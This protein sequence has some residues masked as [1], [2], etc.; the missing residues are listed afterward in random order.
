MKKRLADTDSQEQILESFKALAGDK[1]FVTE[2]DLRRS[3]MDNEK[4]SYLIA[5]RYWALDSFHKYNLTHC[6][7]EHAQEG[8]WLRLHCLGQPSL[9]PL[10]SG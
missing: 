6:Y 7:A 5:V 3:G 10:N 2:E 9:Q 4:V 8:Q 1:D